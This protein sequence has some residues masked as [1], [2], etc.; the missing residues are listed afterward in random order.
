MAVLLLSALTLLSAV[1]AWRVAVPAEPPSLSLKSP[2]VFRAEI[3]VGCFFFGYIVLGI[4]IHT[5]RLGRPPKRLGFGMVSFESEEM[6]KTVEALTEGAEAFKALE[7]RLLEV[8]ARLGL[9]REETRALHGHLEAFE[10][11]LA[12]LKRLVAD[13]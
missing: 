6:E 9:G 3:F 7:M 1:A 12:D 13:G 4:L 5:V 11:A 8:E 2:A 10:S